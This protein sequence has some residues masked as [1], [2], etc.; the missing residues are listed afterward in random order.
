[1]YM[2]RLNMVYFLTICKLVVT[3]IFNAMGVVLPEQEISS[4]RTSGVDLI[5]FNF[6]A[7]F[8]P[9]LHVLS[10]KLTTIVFFIMVHFIHATNR[11]SCLV[12]PLSLTC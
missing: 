1:M 12:S 9:T 3:F 2:T 8:H 11:L 4:G 5:V 10:C 6:L 7:C